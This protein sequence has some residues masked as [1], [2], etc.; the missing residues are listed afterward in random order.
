MDDNPNVDVLF[1]AAQLAGRVAEMGRAITEY[2]RGSEL[3]VVALTNGAMPFAS[4]LIRAIPLPI[5]VD[6]LAVAS[7]HKDRRS[8][9][10][11]FRSSLKLNP[12]G[13]RVL[14]VDEVLDSGHTL[15]RVVDY[16]L[17]LHA[18][19]VHTAVMLTK[20][21]RRPADAIQQADWS[22]FNAPDLFL[23]GYGLDSNEYYRNLPFVGVLR[24]QT[25]AKME[26]VTKQVKS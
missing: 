21:I 15:R 4:D 14:V 13:R 9:E 10:L 17:G 24:D 3:T 12:A 25:I 18:A 1:S 7:Y 6:S 5:Y 8:D 2:F 26:D 16:L 19:D 20:D 22:G 11:A 23:V